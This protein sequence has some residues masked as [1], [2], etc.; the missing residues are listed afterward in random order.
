MTAADVAA[1]KGKIGAQKLGVL[2]HS[3]PGYLVEGYFHTYQPA[4]HR[5]MNPDVDHLEGLDY[6]RGVAD[7]YGVEKESV[8]QIYGIVRDAQQKFTHTL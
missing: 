3:V 8:G 1:G 4:R 6:A 5:G 7:Y 2:N